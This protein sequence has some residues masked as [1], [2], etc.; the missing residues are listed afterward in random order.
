MNIIFILFQNLVE[1][2]LN[3]TLNKRFAICAN[4][5]RNGESKQYPASRPFFLFCI[6]TFTV[7]Q[8]INDDPYDASFLH[9][10]EIRRLLTTFTSSMQLSS[11]ANISWVQSQREEPLKQIEIRI[12][13]AYFSSQFTVQC[14]NYGNLSNAIL[15]NISFD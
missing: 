9:T 15:L 8:Q 2:F 14:G 1:D 11:F 12:R 3:R 7:K 6:G 5:L 13:G 4:N 10:I